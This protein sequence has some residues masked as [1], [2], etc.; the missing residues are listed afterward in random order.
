MVAEDTVIGGYHIPAGVS[1]V[2]LYL[3]MNFVYV[4][5]TY[6][7]LYQSLADVELLYCYIRSRRIYLPRPMPMA[8]V[9]ICLK[10]H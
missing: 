8:V 10:I 5:S 7:L 9:V 6:V 4:Y 3:Y 2:H 1:Y